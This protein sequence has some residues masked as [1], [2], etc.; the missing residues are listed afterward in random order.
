VLV[1]DSVLTAA[2]NALQG[3]AGSD[4]VLN[5]GTLLHL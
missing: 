4:S 5:P 1:P 2:K 3:P